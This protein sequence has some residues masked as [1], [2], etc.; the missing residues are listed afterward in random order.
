M[1]RF[2]HL[3]PDAV[4]GDRV[5]FEAA[6]AHHLGRVLRATVGDVVQAVDPGGALLSVRLTAIAARG[7]EG[8]IV[9]RVPLATESP[10]DLTLAQ[11]VPKGDKMDGIVRMAT[12]RR[13]ELSTSNH[14]V[15]SRKGARTQTSTAG[16]QRLPVQPPS[17]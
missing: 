9:S 1:T 11:G 15:S 17:K 6:A 8:L 12:E 14:R 3:G 13:S 10:L 2:L 7:A 4:H 5:A 16:P